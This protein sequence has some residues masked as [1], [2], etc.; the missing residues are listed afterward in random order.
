VLAS[1]SSTFLVSFLLESGGGVAANILCELKGSCQPQDF[2]LHKFPKE[3]TRGNISGRAKVDMRC[4]LRFPG[5]RIEVDK[6]DVFDLML[7]F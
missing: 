1:P 2:W 6:R 7:V 5:N 4:I 3:V